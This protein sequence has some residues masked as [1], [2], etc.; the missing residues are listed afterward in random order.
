M[1]IRLGF[2]ASGRGTSIESLVKKIQSCELDG[3]KAEVI[4][5][6]KK[7]GEAEVYERV[8]KLGIRIEH[9]EETF[10]QLEILKNLNIELILGMGIL[11]KLE[12]KS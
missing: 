2:L 1:V 8:D 6:N 4:L 3:F 12:M 9:A 10:K 7:R 11:K 5:C